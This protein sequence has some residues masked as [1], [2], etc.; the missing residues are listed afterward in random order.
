MK[1]TQYKEMLMK[2][3]NEEWISWRMAL[4][5]KSI[6]CGI[7]TLIGSSSSLALIDIPQIDSILVS[8]KSID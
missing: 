4:A 1:R 3:F 7:N 5:T 6:S 2:P 8:P